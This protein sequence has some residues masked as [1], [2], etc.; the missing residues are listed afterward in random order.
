MK[1]L[2]WLNIV[3]SGD[4]CLHL[5]LHT[6]GGRC[7]K[8][9]YVVSNVSSKDHSSCT[10]EDTQGCYDETIR[11]WDR[12]R[13]RNLAVWDQHR[14]QDRDQPKFCK[15]KT[16]TNE[17]DFAAS[18]KAS[19]VVQLWNNKTVYHSDCCTMS[20][21]MTTTLDT[22]QR[23]VAG[24]SLTWTT[25]N[26]LSASNSTPRMWTI[27]EGWMV[28]TE[29]RIG[30][31]VTWQTPQNISFGRVNHQIIQ[32]HPPGDVFNA[33]RKPVRTKSGLTMKTWYMKPDVTACLTGNTTSDKQNSV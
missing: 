11:H 6:P 3:H 26:N 20:K 2:T 13:D 4:C 30:W 15:T 17:T 25:R 10:A 9:S 32:C 12:E 14:H 8:R 23:I 31:L 28:V 7:H 18:E 16:K 24:G 27:A 33:D 21:C 5:V 29:W 22:M 19:T 1:Q